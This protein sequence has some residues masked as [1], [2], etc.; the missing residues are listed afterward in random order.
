MAFAMALVQ[1]WPVVAQTSPQVTAIVTAAL[2]TPVAFVAV[3]EVHVLA[4]ALPSA[5]VAI[6]PVVLQLLGPLY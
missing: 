4:W 3:T 2:S 1:F 6:S 5:L